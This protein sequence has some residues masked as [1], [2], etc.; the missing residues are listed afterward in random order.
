M[1]NHWVVDLNFDEDES[2]TTCTAALSG[3]SA[4]GARGTGTARRNPGDDADA[5]IGEELAAA[6]ACNDLAQQLIGRA[7]SGIEGHTHTPAQLSF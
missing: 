3:F 1:Q 4:P 2:R 5:A 7:A 6:R